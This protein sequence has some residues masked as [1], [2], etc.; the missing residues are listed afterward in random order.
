MRCVV[1]ARSSRDRVAA[2]SDYVLQQDI[3]VFPL[4]PQVTSDFMKIGFGCYLQMTQINRRWATASICVICGSFSALTVLQ[5]CGDDVYTGTHDVQQRC[6]P[7]PHLRRDVLQC[8]TPCPHAWPDRTAV[9]HGVS[10]R[11]FRPNR[12]VAQGVHACGP[13]APRCCTGCLH[14][15]PDRTAV[16]HEVSTRVTRPNRRVARSVHT[17]DPT[18]PRCCTSADQ[19]FTD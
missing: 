13:A 8:C 19:R 17:C 7:R 3:Q 2:P 9:L 4:P 12:G 18:E 10:T 1:V 15:W 11:V 6:A 5:R 16:L 14:V